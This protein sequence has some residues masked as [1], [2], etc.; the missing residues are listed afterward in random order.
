MNFAINCTYMYVLPMCNSSVK[1]LA[2]LRTAPKFLAIRYLFFS[3]Q[4]SYRESLQEGASVRVLFPDTE[5][6]SIDLPVARCVLA[7]VKILRPNQE[8]SDN[9]LVH[10]KQQAWSVL[11]VHVGVW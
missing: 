2:N 11:Q 4:L 9:D 1:N 6:G 10:Y 5:A 3:T 8:S 7:A